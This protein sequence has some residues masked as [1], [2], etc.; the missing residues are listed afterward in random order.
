M[1]DECAKSYVEGYI[2]GLNLDSSSDF[3]NAINEISKYQSFLFCKITK[4]ENKLEGN[5]IIT[6]Y[7]QVIVVEFFCER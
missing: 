3:T 6:N 5:N 7:W 2:K 4:L 1:C